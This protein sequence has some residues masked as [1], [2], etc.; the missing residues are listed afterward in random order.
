MASYLR[1][2]R[3]LD[4]GRREE[5]ADALE[6]AA[7][8]LRVASSARTAAEIQARKTPYADDGFRR[9]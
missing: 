2:K 1:D 6:R 3:L 9:D 5:V 4:A 8:E 7:R